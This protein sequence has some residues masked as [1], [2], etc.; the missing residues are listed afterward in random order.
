MFSIT[1]MPVHVTLS[2]AQQRRLASGLTV[3]L[4]HEALHGGPHEVHLSVAQ[5]S[6]L[7]TAQRTGKGMRLQLSPAQLRTGGGFL[8]Q[9]RRAGRFIKAAIV[10]LPKPRDTVP[11]A[12]RSF[13]QR[14]GQQ[15]VVKLSVGREPIGG[16]ISALLNLLSRGAYDEAKRKLGYES[17]Y[18]TYLLL[19]LS[20]GQ[21]VT[22]ERN[23]VVELRPAS[24]KKQ[25]GQLL[26]VPMYAQPTLA[27]VVT[28]AEQRQ[29]GFWQY[30]HDSNNCQ[31]LVNT[32]LQSSPE[33]S[34][35]AVAEANVFYRQDSAALAASI[36]IVGNHVAKQLTDLAASGDRLLYGDGLR[37]RPR[38]VR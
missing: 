9:L 4:R 32:V 21:P 27:E 10:G 7:T 2:A 12:V 5:A 28:R 36:G 14:H 37:R 26:Q 17:V 22:L 31:A 3:Q 1:A 19:E 16:V 6:R 11:P 34:K 15:R 20:N 24:T 13:L 18:H 8:E 33:V 23:H 29:P 30:S 25:R 35:Q 38:R